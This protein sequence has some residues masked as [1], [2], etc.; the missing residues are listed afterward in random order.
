MSI[1]LNTLVILAVMIIA[2][3]VLIWGAVAVAVA[4]DPSKINHIKASWHD[5]ASLIGIAY[6]IAYWSN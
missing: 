5:I 2:F 1:L 4:K 6:L 3:N